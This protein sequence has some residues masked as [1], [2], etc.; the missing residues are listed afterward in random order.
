MKRLALI[1]LSLPIWLILSL[2]L[3]IDSEDVT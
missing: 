3:A 1:L 2:S